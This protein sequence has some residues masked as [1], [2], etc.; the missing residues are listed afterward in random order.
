MVTFDQLVAWAGADNVTRADPEAGSGWRISED[1]KALLVE[2]GVPAVA[3]LIEQVVFQSESEPAL[4]TA[5][6][7]P[8]YRL[9]LDCGGDGPTEQPSSFG[10]DPETGAVFYVMPPG[11]AWFANSSID[12]WLR[13]LH[14][15]GQHVS[16]SELLAEPAGPEEYLS[17]EDEERALAEL[18]RIGQELKRIDPAA[19]DGYTGF[20]WPELLDRWLY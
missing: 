15:Y 17:E 19:F 16:E 20:V 2:V 14:H 7:S 4:N 6:G 13:T 18:A 5:S 10:V 8:L 3:R 9:T 12:L 11:D 1:M